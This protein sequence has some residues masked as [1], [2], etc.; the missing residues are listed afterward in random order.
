MKFLK[1]VG[2]AQRGRGVFSIQ[3]YRDLKQKDMLWVLPLALLGILSALATMGFLIFQQFSSFYSLGL[4]L[5]QPALPFFFLTMGIWAFGFL[6]AIPLVFSLL[7]YS[8]DLPLLFSL[9][10]S[11][12]QVVLSKLAIIYGYLLAISLVFSTMMIA[13]LINMGAGNPAQFIL[14]ALGGFVLP[15]FPMALAVFFVAFFLRVIDFQRFRILFEV[16]GMFLALLLIMGI[17]LLFSQTMADQGSMDNSL[18]GLAKMLSA[19]IDRFPPA[20]W[21]AKALS[22]NSVADYLFF[23]MFSVAGVYVAWFFSTHTLAHILE[24]QSSKKRSSGRGQYRL[25]QTIGI[26]PALIKKDLFILVSNSTF[27]FQGMG[28]MLILPILLIIYSVAIP[29][30]ALEQMLQAIEAVSSWMPLIIL[31]A[32]SL[33]TGL[34]SFGCTTISREGKSIQLPLSLPLSGHVHFKAKMILHLAIYGSIFV[35][36]SFILTLLF[37]L[38]LA[39]WL[40]LLPAGLILVFISFTVGLWIDFSR[41][42]LNWNHPMEA[43]KNNLNVLINM[44]ILMAYMAVLGLGCYALVA[45]FHLSHEIVLTGLTVFL[46]FPAKLLYEKLKNRAV[47]FYSAGYPGS[48]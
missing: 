10:V 44:G 12:G 42:V 19:L 33:F 41:P 9:P 45:Y 17:N 38:S 14:I 30:E 29:K 35:I 34:T 3:F 24:K 7:Y 6:T 22:R 15:L 36:D 11:R 16:L 31:G 13:V 48:G 21:A 5:N 25:A 4:V 20:A 26:V 43:V 28:E 32:A 46:V 1:L 37:Q 18:S 39:Q 8:K 40:I 47:Q 2:A 27:I 23:V